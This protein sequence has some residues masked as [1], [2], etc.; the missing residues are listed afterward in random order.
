MNDMNYVS[1]II[2]SPLVS[3]ASRVM[4]YSSSRLTDPESLAIHT[5][6]VLMIGV[7]LI[8]RI[9]EVSPE[10]VINESLYM[11]KALSHDLEEI[12]TGDVPRPLKYSSQEV[13]KSLQVI[14]DSAARE[15]FTENFYD[16]KRWLTLWETAKEGKEGHLLKLAD[17]LTVLRKSIY[18]VDILS[19]LTM[20][21]VVK[22]VA[23]YFKEILDKLD[24]FLFVYTEDTTK[25]YLSKLISESYRLAVE[26]MDTHTQSPAYLTGIHSYE[27][28]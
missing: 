18:E 6:E 16:S 3:R 28:D 8:D 20:L 5:H 4:R 21:D 23:F 2:N 10:E 11:S 12:S 24:E 25:A 26:C 15:L 13:R 19:N 27:Y 17:L 9:K 14:A 22:N 1:G 7:L